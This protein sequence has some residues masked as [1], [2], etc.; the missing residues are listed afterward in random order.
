MELIALPTLSYEQAQ[1]LI[2][3]HAGS[4]LNDAEVALQA[5]ESE[6]DDFRPAE[7]RF[8]D[9]D[10]ELDELAASCDCLI[11]NGNL[12][13]R[14]LLETCHEV[15]EGA[16]IVLG[17]VTAGNVIVHD[18][19]C[20]ISGNFHAGHVYANSSNNCGMVVGGNVQAES[21]V[22][23][24]Q[25]IHVM[26]DVQTDLVLSGMN[27]IQ[28]DGQ[29]HAARRLD[30]ATGVQQKLTEVFQPLCVEADPESKKQFLEEDVYCNMLR[31]GENPLIV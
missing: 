26:G 23:F 28:T 12:H 8:C 27:Q 11:V 7:I 29:E 14:G 2:K 30:R 4:V 5:H 16:L 25:H 10:F 6:E 18:S 19:W 3:K 13:V 17:N 15:E 21:L 9:G 1:E 31:L 22:E 24:G 20:V